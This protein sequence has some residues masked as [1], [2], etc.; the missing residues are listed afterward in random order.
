M[1]GHTRWDILWIRK[2]HF[3]PVREED[4]IVG[5]VPISPNKFCEVKIANMSF[6]KLEVSKSALVAMETK[7]PGVNFLTLVC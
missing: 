3:I 5:C 2:N 7:M 1:F 4:G 6:S